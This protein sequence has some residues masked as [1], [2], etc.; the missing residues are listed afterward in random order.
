MCKFNFLKGFSFISPFYPSSVNLS[1]FFFSFFLSFFFAWFM[2]SC[3]FLS[4]KLL[5][6]FLCFFKRE[7]A[8]WIPVFFFKFVTV[9]V[10]K[11]KLKQCQFKGKVTFRSIR[12]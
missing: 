7:A 12:F 9:I 10:A 2:E 6:G 5:H 4:A 3:G 11:L 1:L 8:L